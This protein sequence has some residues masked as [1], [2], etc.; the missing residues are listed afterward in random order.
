MVSTEHMPFNLFK[1][2]RHNAPK[3]VVKLYSITNNLNHSQELISRSH[4]LNN[5][6]FRSFELVNSHEIDMSPLLNQLITD[7]QPDDVFYDIGANIGTYSLVLGQCMSDEGEIVAFEP[8]PKTYKRLCA[9]LGVG[10]SQQNWNAMNI[11]ASN[12]SETTVIYTGLF[13]RYSTLSKD[14]A[15]DHGLETEVEIESK[16]LDDLDIE[17]PDILKIDTEGHELDVLEGAS[18]LI[19][20]EAPDI[21]IE[22][23]DKGAYSDT[24][25]MMC[26]ESHGYTVKKNNGYWHTYRE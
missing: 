24:E 21:Y 11:A 25:L 2:L 4:E 15:I 12:N 7:I 8:V 10:L 22:P 3:K 5:I 6:G 23:H 17:P 19:E 26:L 20:S 13:D 16:R 18:S 14:N 9:N 1:S